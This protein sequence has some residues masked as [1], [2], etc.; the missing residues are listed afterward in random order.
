MLFRCRIKQMINIAVRC[1]WISV[2]DPQSLNEWMNV[3]LIDIFM[4]IY[5][6]SLNSFA[7]CQHRIWKKTERYSGKTPKQLVH[8]H[9]LDIYTIIF[10]RKIV[11]YFG[12][13]L[14]CFVCLNLILMVPIVWCQRDMLFITICRYKIAGKRNPFKWYAIFFRK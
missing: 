11:I 10:I 14:F 12:F 5:F 3:I 6:I 8:I 2:F 13:V 9:T 7:L 1:F 4:C